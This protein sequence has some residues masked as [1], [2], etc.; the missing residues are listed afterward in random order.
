MHNALLVLA[1]MHVLPKV[2]NSTESELR[3][4]EK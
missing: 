1:R 4:A 2:K 3:N